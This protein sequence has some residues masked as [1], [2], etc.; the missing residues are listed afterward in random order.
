[1]QALFEKKIKFPVH[2]NQPFCKWT[3]PAL[4]RAVRLLGNGDVAAAQ[5]P[6]QTVSSKPAY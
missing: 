6:A 2:A 3:N 5:A 1:M 4:Q